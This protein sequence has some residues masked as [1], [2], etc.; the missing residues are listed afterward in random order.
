MLGYTYLDGAELWKP[1]LGKKP[2][3]NLFDTQRERFHALCSWMLHE[4]EHSSGCHS[5]T[6]YG[7]GDFG[8]CDCGLEAMMKIVMN[9]VE[10]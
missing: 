2:D 5:H 4:A 9:E 6:N 8:S 7:L 10:T 3:F 1:P